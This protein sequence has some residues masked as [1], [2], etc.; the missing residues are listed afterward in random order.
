M[1]LQSRI[2]F[3][4]EAIPQIVGN[5]DTGTAKGKLAQYCVCLLKDV[6]PTAFNAPIVEGKPHPLTVEFPMPKS[7]TPLPAADTWGSG[8]LLK[9]ID[10]PAPAA[11]APAPHVPTPPFNPPPPAPKAP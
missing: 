1:N 4:A 7:A 3:L 5:A 2:A 6:P 9:W 11:P 8:G 10:T